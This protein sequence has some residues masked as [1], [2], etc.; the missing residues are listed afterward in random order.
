MKETISRDLNRFSLPQLS[1]MHIQQFNFSSDI[2]LQKKEILYTFQVFIT[3]LCAM[4]GVQVTV[5]PLLKLY[6]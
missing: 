6:I 4:L 2:F 1:P 5:N 3:F